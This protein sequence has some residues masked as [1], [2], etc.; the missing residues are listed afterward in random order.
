MQYG[1]ALEFPNSNVRRMLVPGMFGQ[2]LSIDLLL[3]N[4]HGP[5]MLMYTLSMHGKA[6]PSLV[7]KRSY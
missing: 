4:S 6:E 7:R 5:Y 3:S 1:W 2:Q